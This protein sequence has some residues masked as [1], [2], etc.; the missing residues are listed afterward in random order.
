M[1]EP[2][3]KQFIALSEDI[4]AFRD[5]LKAERGMAENTV[6]AYGRDLDRYAHW[7]ADEGLADY[8]KPTVRALSNYLCQ[9]REEDLAPSSI[10]RHRTRNYAS[11]KIS[12]QIRHFRSPGSRVSE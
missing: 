11:G 2:Q 12:R 10:A 3:S 1:S 6:L 7:V 8:L 4:R 9:L 5:Y